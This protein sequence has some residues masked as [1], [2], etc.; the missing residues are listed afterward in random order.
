MTERVRSRIGAPARWA[1][2]AP[3]DADPTGGRHVLD[4]D[5]GLTP[6]FTTLRRGE[7]RRPRPQ[8]ARRAL[9]PV[10]DPVPYSSDPW[11]A[12]IP[13]VPPLPAAGGY[14]AADAYGAPLSVVPAAEPPVSATEATAWWGIPVVAGP[15]TEHGAYA[16]H[17]AY[18][19]GV[20]D[21]DRYGSGSYDAAPYD[22][23][24][25][26]SAPYDSAPYGP[27]FHEPAPYVPAPHDRGAYDQAAYDQGA[28]DRGAYDRGG[29]DQAAYDRGPYTHDPLPHQPAAYEPAA[30]EPVLYGPP[31]RFP[32]HDPR[33][34]QYDPLTDT[35]RHHRRLAPAGW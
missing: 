14:G 34:Y 7:W 18:D 8:S 3:E 31:H 27:A 30:Y 4:Q 25:Y 1:G 6:I 5:A 29:Y 12:P 35:G 15:A 26:D 9:R 11:T 22:A 33:P 28:Y 21:P 19:R 24:R 2:Q 13:V 32:R 23:T 16:E 17:G 20:D 10:P